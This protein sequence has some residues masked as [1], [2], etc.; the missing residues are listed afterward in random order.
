MLSKVETLNWACICM[1]IDILAR[2]ITEG[3]HIYSEYFHRTKHWLPLI[4]VTYA[5]LALTMCYQSFQCL[6]FVGT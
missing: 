6:S 3:K 2:G 4:T 5:C 1:V